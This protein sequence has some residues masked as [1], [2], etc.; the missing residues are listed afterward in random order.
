MQHSMLFPEKFTGKHEKDRIESNQFA[1]G[2]S[3]I[4]LPS[5]AISESNE[6]IIKSI[7][8]GLPEKS[9]SNTCKENN[10]KYIP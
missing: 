10:K 4:Y 6:Q 3:Q 8:K 2:F 5:T 9:Y 1:S 7:N